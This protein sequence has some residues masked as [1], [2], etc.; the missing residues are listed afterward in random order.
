M[1]G[2]IKVPVVDNQRSKRGQARMVS[3]LKQIEF[4]GEVWARNMSIQL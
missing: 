4:V 3:E 1:D 2:W